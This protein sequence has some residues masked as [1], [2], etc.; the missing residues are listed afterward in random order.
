MKIIIFTILP[1]LIL[2]MNVNADADEVIIKLPT[3]ERNIIVYKEVCLGGRLFASAISAEGY[4]SI[5]SVALVQVR[6]GTNGGR[7]VQCSNE[8]NK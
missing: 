7:A 1:L 6:I 2:S 3:N 8:I 4:Q 5:R